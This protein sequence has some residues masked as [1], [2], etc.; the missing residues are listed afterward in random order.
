MANRDPDNVSMIDGL[1][2]KIVVII[3]LSYKPEIFLNPISTTIYVTN[4]LFNS[5]Y[6]LN[7]KKQTT[8]NVRYTGLQLCVTIV[9]LPPYYT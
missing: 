3:T 5:I 7:G 6:M 8:I 9:N 1:T 2:I 4:D